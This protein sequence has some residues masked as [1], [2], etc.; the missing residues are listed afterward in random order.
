MSGKRKPI[1]KGA[2]HAL[3]LLKSS[4]SR[5]LIF[6]LGCGVGFAFYPALNPE[7]VASSSQK[8]LVRACFSPEGQ[9]TNF[10]ISAIAEAKSSICVMAYSFTSPPIANALVEAY[11]RGVD[12]R[13]LFDKSQLKEKYS[14]IHFL[15]QKGIP[16]FIDPAI[17]IAHNK[18]MVIDDSKVL[19]GSFNWT[20]AAESRNA[21]NI[22]L[23]D[24]P[25]LAQIYKKNWEKRAYST[26]KTS[27]KKRGKVTANSNKGNIS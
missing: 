7:W 19:T 21:E 17:G 23:I 1:G 13:I 20:R 2:L 8:A 24:D 26:K 18:T 4:P 5:F 12:V 16:L 9:C 10:V 6:F 3:F 14:Q 25:S 15:S 27:R 11:E 22:L